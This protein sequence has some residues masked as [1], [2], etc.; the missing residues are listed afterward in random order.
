MYAKNLEIYVP[1]FSK[2]SWDSIN[3]DICTFVVDLKSL[4]FV[5]HVN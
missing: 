3:I 4:Y 1:S 2:Y 5:S